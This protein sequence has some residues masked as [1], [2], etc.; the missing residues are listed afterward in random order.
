MA[1]ALSPSYLRIGGTA[2][3]L[4]TFKAKPP[5]KKLRPLPLEYYQEK[6]S[7]EK[8][9]YCTNDIKGQKVCENLKNALYKNR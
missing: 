7:N 6:T 2:A 5:P 4:L 8:D 9:C 3:D 1:K